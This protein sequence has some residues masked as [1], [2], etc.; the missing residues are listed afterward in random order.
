MTNTHRPTEHPPPKNTD[1][2]LT[3]ET[4]AFIEASM[5]AAVKRGI[6][7]A[8]T[9]E[10]AAVFWGAGLRVLQRSASEHTGRF[11]IGGLWGLARKASVFLLLGGLVYSVGGWTALAKFWHAI[12]T[13]GGAG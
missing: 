7:E 10:M 8:M 11:V 5:S 3:P 1:V 12:W 4:L 9:E 13:G 6:E 2:T